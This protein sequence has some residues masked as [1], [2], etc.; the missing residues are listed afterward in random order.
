MVTLF[1]QVILGTA[2]VALF[3][4]PSDPLYEPLG[5]IGITVA[6]VALVWAI[7]R[8]SG[9]LPWSGLRLTRS[10]SAVPHALL[11]VLAGAAAVVAAN[12]ASVAIGVATW[13]PWDK[14]VAPA[15][16]SLP[17]AVAYIV[18]GQAFPEE[19]LWRGHLYDTLS[20]RLS[21]RMVLVV[22]SVAFGAMHIVSQSPADTVAEKLLYLVQAAA[23]GFACAAARARSG[24]LW[25]AIGVH[26]GYHLGDTLLP[27]Q[28]RQFGAQLALLALTLTLTG[29]I[30]LRT[31]R[32]DTHDP[33]EPVS[34]H[35][36]VEPLDFLATSRV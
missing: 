5:M 33:S 6:S 27:T 25:M 3:M 34:P 28:D 8:L 32:N 16:T 12:A 7:R 15:L 14:V 24:A 10:R 21:P 23:L 4:D 11:G 22:V 29:L 31:A 19:L 9:R 36:G 17:V 13:L 18:L 35:G 2:P 26:T 1:A 20:R 30:T